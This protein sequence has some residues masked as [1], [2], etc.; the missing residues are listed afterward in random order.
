MLI[1]GFEGHHRIFKSLCLG[2]KIKALTIQLDP[3]MKMDGIQEMAGYIFK[4]SMV[5]L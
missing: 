4:V 3:D 2:L 1:P 5:D